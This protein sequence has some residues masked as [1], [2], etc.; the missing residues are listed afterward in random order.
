LCRESWSID[1]RIVA[2]PEVAG[3]ILHLGVSGHWRELHGSLDSVRYRARPFIHTTD[4]RFVDTGNFDATGER[5]IGAE[6][7]WIRGPFH[8]TAESHWLTARRPG[9][10]DPTFNGG[11]AEV[12]Y[13]LT[14]DDTAYKSGVYERIRPTNPVDKGGFGA[15]QVNVRY[16]WLD[17][18]DK[19][20]IGGRQEIAGLSLI[21]IPI[22][23]VRFIANY[24]HLW[25]HDAA[26]KVGTNGNYDADA[27]GMRAQVDF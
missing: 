20:I 5:G 26:V 18:N 6:L 14:G 25:L 3:G 24:G 9:L 27:F 1:G 11:Y 7:A 13:L 17:L 15:V 4:V 23:Y 8:A 21:W 16:D 19:D 10:P 12:G 22:D 2:M